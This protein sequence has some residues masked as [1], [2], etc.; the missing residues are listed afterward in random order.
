MPQIG[1]TINDADKLQRI[2]EA[3]G[4]AKNLGGPAN[5]AQVNAWIW[6]LVKAQVKNI[7]AEERSKA[8][9][10]PTDLGDAT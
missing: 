2:R 4:I 5:G 8:I 9:S 3:C 7:E 1:P 6:E 10:E